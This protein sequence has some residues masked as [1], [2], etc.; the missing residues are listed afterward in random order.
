MTRIGTRF[1]VAPTG[2][3][4]DT[5]PHMPGTVVGKVPKAAV[6]GATDLTPQE[7]AVLEK[8]GH[9]IGDSLP[10]L[11]CTMTGER[12]TKEAEA[13]RKQAADIS[14][15]TPIDPTT[16]PLT[17]PVPTPIEELPAEQQERA[18]QSFEEMRELQEVATIAAMSRSPEQQA[19]HDAAI[20]EAREL[21]AAMAATR[22]A[23]AHAAAEALPEGLAAVPGAAAAVAVARHAAE[24]KQPQITLVDDLGLDEDAPATL[25]L[26]KAP[27]PEPADQ[28]DEVTRKEAAAATETSSPEQVSAGSNIAKAEAKEFCPQCNFDLSA[29]LVSI[30]QIDKIEYLA[31]LLGNLPRFR[32]RVSLFGGRLIAVFRS[33]TPKELDMTTAQADHDLAAGDVVTTVQYLRTAAFYKMCASVESVERVGKGTTKLPELASIDIE[34]TDAP[35]PLVALK[36]YLDNEVFLVA[37]VRAALGQAWVKFDALLQLLEANADTPDFFAGIE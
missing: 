18:L 13:I 9:R 33:L 1:P 11:T 20:R 34:G 10:D 19:I 5:L 23:D 21:Q 15:L 12:M 35:T 4:T 24:A 28:M 32:R 31:L 2:A 22:A 14:G 29:K 6:K 27:R 7:R 25:P 17:P 37:S 30:E 36:E 8:A 3:M 16:P 26:K